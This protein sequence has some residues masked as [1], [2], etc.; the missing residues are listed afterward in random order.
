[1]NKKQIIVM[2]VGIV[3][4]IIIGLNTETTETAYGHRYSNDP[5]KSVAVTSDYG[6]LFVRLSG[7]VLATI[8]A[9]YTLKDKKT[10]L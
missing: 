3:I 9:I 10:E 8:A 5:I 7:T 4:Y 2:W 1:M 6:S